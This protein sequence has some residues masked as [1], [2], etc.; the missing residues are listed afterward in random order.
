MT[1]PR[2]IDY[3]EIQKVFEETECGE[4]AARWMEE[5][6]LGMPRLHRMR[7]SGAASVMEKTGHEWRELFGEG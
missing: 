2:V 5:W 3:D 4:F 6:Q 7:R 1:G